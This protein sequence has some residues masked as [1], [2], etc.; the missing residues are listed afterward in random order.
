MNKSESIA[1]LAKALS[2]FQAEVT[3]PANTAVNPF[4]KSKYAP[5][6]DILTLVRPILGKYGLSVVQDPSTN[7]GDVVIKTTLFHSSGEFIES[8]PLTLKMEKVTAQGA[9]SAITYARRYAISAILGLSSEDDDDGNN[10]EPNKKPNSAPKKDVKP[11][12]VSDELKAI[13]AE[14]NALASEKAKANREAT[15]GAI[16]EYHASGNPNG[17]KELEVAKK[18]L[19]ALKSLEV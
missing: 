9:G 11:E 19:E 5:L 12:P 18:V 6:S 3:N 7:G 4:F 8:D 13:I 10:A 16:K 14:I 1:N 15:L 17:I 2:E